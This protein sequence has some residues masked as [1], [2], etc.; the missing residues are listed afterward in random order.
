LPHAVLRLVIKRA[1]I[2]TSIQVDSHPRPTS[3][4][5]TLADRLDVPTF[6]LPERHCLF[7][8]YSRSP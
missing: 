2:D 7:T 8:G 3:S 5:P 4:L 1:T 6:L